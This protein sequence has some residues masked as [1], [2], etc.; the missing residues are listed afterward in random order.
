MSRRFLGHRVLYTGAASATASC[1][2]PALHGMQTWRR[3][4]RQ[5]VSYTDSKQPLLYTATFWR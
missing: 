3:R 1:Y 2:S 5:C 4:K